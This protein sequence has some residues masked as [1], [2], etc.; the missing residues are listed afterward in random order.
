MDESSVS[1]IIP[2]YNAERTIGRALDSVFAQTR[3]PDEVLVVDDG[4]PHSLA[5]ALRPFGDRVRVLRQPN[6][7]AASARNRGIEQTH[8]R[9]I[10]FLDA[11]DYWYPT[12]LE[13]QCEILKRYP[14]VGLVGAWFH[15]EQPGADGVD[16]ILDKR[17]FDK[18]LKVSGEQTFVVA[19]QI[20]MGTV[21]VRRESLADRRFVS[22]LEPAEDRDLW[23]R[24]AAAMPIYLISEPLAAA[25]LEPQ[26]LSRSNIDR[27][28]G[29]M[30]RVIERNAELLTPR[31]RRYWQALT[32]RRWA[33]NHLTEGRPGPAFRQALRRL[34]LEPLSLEG[35]WVVAKC[36]M[37]ACAPPRSVPQT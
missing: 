16:A 36:G 15:E 27:D 20:W 21:V 13:R 18:V 23:I 26:S 7:G 14:H 4:S 10:A 19:T 5:T 3:L 37:R 17:F 29:N 11:D 22:G 8:G 12:K 9:L 30:L 24:L 25:V 32:Y 1:V 2:A 33:A 35:W 34:R 28:C 6:G 31:A